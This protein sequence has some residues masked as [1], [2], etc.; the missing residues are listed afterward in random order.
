MTEWSLVTEVI[1]ATAGNT[2][3]KDLA[4]YKTPMTHSIRMY[5]NCLFISVGAVSVRY[6]YRPH[7][8]RFLVLK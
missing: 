2:S 4:A 6:I 7:C 3:D 8:M 5:R 1:A